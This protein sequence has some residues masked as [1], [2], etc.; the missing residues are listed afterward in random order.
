MNRWV[1]AIL[2]L[3]ALV[4][5]ISPGIIG[6]MA[7]GN[8]EAVIDQTRSDNPGVDIATERFDQGWFTTEG[9]H[10]VD[11]SGGQFADMTEA[12]REAT[13]YDELF[14][15]IVDTRLDHGL[16]PL[17]SLG[18]DGGSLSPGLANSISTFHIDPGNGE[19]I[20]IPGGLYSQVGLNGDSES[21]LLLEQAT[22]TIEE[23]TVEFTGA[24]VDIVADARGQEIAVDGKLLPWTVEADDGR[25]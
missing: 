16:I 1:V 22:Y 21:R 6:R 11:F 2:V 25:L 4:L 8:V 12:Y 24:D 13:G 10:R 20:D 3:L 9:R 18:R 5:L 17:T 7:G 14:S 19:L 15:L 23:A